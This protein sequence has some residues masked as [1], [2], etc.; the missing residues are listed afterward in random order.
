LGDDLLS[1]F[2]R[3]V[4][5]PDVNTPVQTLEYEDPNSGNLRRSAFLE[6]RIKFK[7][8]REDPGCARTDEELLQILKNV[9][10]SSRV[11]AIAQSLISRV[12]EEAKEEEGDIGKQNTV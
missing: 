9:F 5:T 8:I 2:R 12:E 3:S 10:S 4:L 11:V 6:G 1:P 7:D